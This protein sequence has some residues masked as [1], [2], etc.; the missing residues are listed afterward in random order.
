MSLIWALDIARVTGFALGRPGE[1]PTARSICLAKAGAISDDLFCAC[2]DWFSAL[3]RDHE[4]PDILILEELLPPIARRGAT[5]TAAQHRL[6]GMHGIVRGLARQAKIPEIASASPASVRGHFIGER[7]AKRE[8]AKQLVVTMCQR[9]GW[10]VD[11]DNCGDALALWSYA[12]AL[13]KPETAL[14]LTPLFG[15]SSFLLRG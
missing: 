12:C 6:A 9:Q 7:A 8:R 2:L 1:Q 14:R 5:S 15:R 11:D 3:L 4:H 13:V 10:I